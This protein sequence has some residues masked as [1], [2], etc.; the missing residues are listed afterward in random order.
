MFAKHH[1][2]KLV[3]V[4][5][6][7]NVVDHEIIVLKRRLC[8]QRDVRVC[9]ALAQFADLRQQIERDTYISH[10]E[11]IKIIVLR[12]RET[13]QQSASQYQIGELEML[14]ETLTKCN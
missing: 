2:A 9:N 8:R 5:G 10:S 6:A 3:R 12:I 14:V 1:G 11:I 7:V 13:K 4:V